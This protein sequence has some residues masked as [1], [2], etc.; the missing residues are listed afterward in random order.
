[1]K[2]SRWLA[3]SAAALTLALSSAAPQSAQAREIVGFSGS[4]SAGTW[5]TSGAMAKTRLYF[6]SQV[7]AD[8]R[9]FVAGGEYGTGGNFMEVYDP[10]T[11]TWAAMTK[12]PATR[13]SGVGAAID[14][15]IYFTTGSS[16]TTTWKGTVS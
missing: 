12:L 8:G 9:V 2:L 15:F 1:M 16:M 7:L 4:Y 13:F 14:G 6:S 5:T 11:N 10:A 3:A